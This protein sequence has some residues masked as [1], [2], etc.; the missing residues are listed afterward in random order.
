MDPAL[1]QVDIVFCQR[2]EF[3]SPHACEQQD[4]CTVGL[5]IQAT[6]NLVVGNNLAIGFDFSF[7]QSDVLKKILAPC[8]GAIVGESIFQRYSQ[9]FF[10]CHCWSI[11][12]GLCLLHPA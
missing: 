3:F 7:W 6:L 8:R 1:V 4:N 2:Q 12:Y 10:N 9:D 11:R 5:L